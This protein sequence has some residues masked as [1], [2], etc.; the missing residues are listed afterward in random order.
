LGDLKTQALE[1]SAETTGALAHGSQAGTHLFF[2][3]FLLLG[4]N[5]VEKLLL[6]RADDVVQVADLK[7]FEETFNVG[8]GNLDVV[9][10]ELV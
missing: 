4:E 9:L 5:S 10:F 7:F 8:G 3:C 2:G 1:E 6:V